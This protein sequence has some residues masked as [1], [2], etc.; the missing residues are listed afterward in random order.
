MF[1]LLA[2]TDKGRG[3]KYVPGKRKTKC[4]LKLDSVC[5]HIFQNKR[6][7]KSSKSTLIVVGAGGLP[8][9]RES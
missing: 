4:L 9:S 8:N 5:H 3:K 7:D 2:Y 1:G 6:Q